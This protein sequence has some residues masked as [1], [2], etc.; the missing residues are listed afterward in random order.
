LA[1]ATYKEYAFYLGD[2]AFTQANISIEMQL[3][4]THESSHADVYIEPGFLLTTRS[5]RYEFNTIREIE[6]TSANLVDSKL[7]F[8]STSVTHIYV[9][10]ASFES[11]HVSSYYSIPPTAIQIIPF[12]RVSSTDYRSLSI[13]YVAIHCS[14][15]VHDDHGN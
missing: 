8:L 7:N 2:H 12:V 10:N 3:H 9:S 14:A 6:T 15:L 1:P 11:V 13:G 4:N 5:G